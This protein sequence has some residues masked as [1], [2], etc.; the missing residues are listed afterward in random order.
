MLPIVTSV[1]VLLE[2]EFRRR[3]LMKEYRRFT[4]CTLLG[5]AYAASIGGISTIIGTPTNAVLTGFLRER[6]QL[7]LSFG[8]WM[9]VGFPLAV[10]LL[11]A[12]YLI[13]TRL[14][15]PMGAI[16]RIDASDL[17]RRKIHD[18]GRVSFQ[19]YAVSLVFAT[20]A[21]AWIARPFLASSF[22]L[23][24]LSD[25][26]I[27]L[28][29]V[30]IL[31]LIPNGRGG[32]GTLLTWEGLLKLP[33]GI[34]LLI[35]GGMALAKA[36]EVSGLVKLIG[37]FVAGGTSSYIFLLIML[38]SITLVLKQFVGNVALATITLPMVFGIADATGIDP[39]LLGAPITFAASFAFMLP[40]STPPNA[41]VF[42]TQHVRMREMMV[43][44][45]LLVLTGLIVLISIHKAYAFMK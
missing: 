13:I 30:L 1:L 2:E 28:T 27:G 39:L 23:S 22:G 26:G 24:A 42:T 12:A 43:A 34:L 5:V 36:L 37:A 9:L 4:L 6:Y 3:N 18:L 31:F 17:I 33:W 25:T 15:F 20:T 32:N 7:E 35:G 16:A 29:G 44:G 38:T 19:Q 11:L 21:A 10:T 8:R 45:A 40:M 41:I 14:L